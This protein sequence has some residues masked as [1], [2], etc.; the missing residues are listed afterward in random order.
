DRVVLDELHPRS[1]EPVQERR[2][3]IE[4]AE[5]IVDDAHA[6]TGTRAVDE[7]IAE[8]AAPALH[9]LEDVVLEIEGMP[10]PC[11]GVEYDRKGLRA[12][13]QNA[14]AVAG[15]E[16]AL[17]HDLLG[18]EVPFERARIRRLPGYPREQ[19]PRLP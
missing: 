9:I 3:R 5:R 4:R 6:N 15:E 8:T 7:Q 12:I 10:C 16:R 1:A 13:A 18:G 2:R 14:H 11:Y 19:R 17:R